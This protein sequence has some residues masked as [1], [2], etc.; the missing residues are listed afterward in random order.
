MKMEHEEPVAE[1]PNA[2][3]RLGIASW[4]KGDGTMKSVKYAWRDKNGRVCRGGEVPIESLEQMMDFAKKHGYIDKAPIIFVGKADFL[5]DFAA[6]LNSK[7]IVANV[8]YIIRASERK[9]TLSFSLKGKRASSDVLKVASSLIDLAK[10][11]VDY[12]NSKK[13]MRMKIS[14][15]EKTIIVT[16][17]DSE[18]NIVKYFEEN[19]GTRFNIDFEF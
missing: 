10:E 17:Q 15:G 12:L 8:E 4:D 11:I 14:A 13:K 1:D 19:K 9:E 3:L 5:E 2:T 6:F 7:N 18:G 16:K